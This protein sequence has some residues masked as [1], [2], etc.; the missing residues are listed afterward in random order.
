MHTIWT[1][2]ILSYVSFTGLCFGKAL[3]HLANI[4][5][6]LIVEFKGHQSIEFTQCAVNKLPNP[7]VTETIRIFIIHP[8][9][10][11]GLSTLKFACVLLQENMYIMRRT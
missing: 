11:A 7:M 8:L 1:D 5:T 3:S 9:P 4:N 10:G 2:R 6:C